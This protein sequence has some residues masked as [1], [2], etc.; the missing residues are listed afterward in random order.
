MLTHARN[1]VGGLV[2]GTAVLVSPAAPALAAPVAVP[3]AQ[4]Q[5]GLVNVVVQDI[6]TGDILS[7]NT[8]NVAVA[9]NLVAQVCGI[10]A[11]AAI[12]AVQLVD[13]SGQRFS[14]ESATQRITV[15]QDSGNRGGNR[16]NSGR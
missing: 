10:T 9:A 11:N 1:L 6:S 5:N 4:V 2:L 15:T 13:Q 12:L 16:G 8:V 14:C 3:E 7:D